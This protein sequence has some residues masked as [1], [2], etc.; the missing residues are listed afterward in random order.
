MAVR[1]REPAVN[2]FLLLELLVLS[3]VCIIFS[4][5]FLTG[6][7]VC[8]RYIACLQLR[9]AAGRFA[10]DILRTQERAL[11]GANL[12]YIEVDYRGQGYWVY[13]KPN[14]GSKRDFASDRPVLFRFTS[15]PVK[16]IHFSL[17]GA[18]SAC[19]TFVLQHRGY[20]ELKMKIM[21]QPVTGRVRIEKCDSGSGW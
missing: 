13:R 8:Q 14:L 19:G 12:A 16:E 2:G 6:V 1:S 18:P 21:L 10:Q 20:P 4:G 17:N 5:M 15:I 11:T 9:T 3:L 7:Q